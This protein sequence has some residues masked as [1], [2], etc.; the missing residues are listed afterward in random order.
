MFLYV[1]EPKMTS[2]LVFLVLFLGLARKLHR[3]GMFE[4]SVKY[5]IILIF[6]LWL[7]P[8]YGADSCSSLL[9]EVS[10]V[11]LQEGRMVT[12]PLK[13]L[14]QQGEFGFF[15]GS[16]IVTFLSD[17]EGLNSPL[18]MGVKFLDE[19]TEI[20]ANNILLS[21]RSAPQD[22]L[23]Q[24]A[25]Q[26]AFNSNKTYFVSGRLSEVQGEWL[27]LIERLSLKEDV[28]ADTESADVIQL[29]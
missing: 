13:N 27:F 15:E 7:N 5:L 10:G 16:H 22:T 25:F 21:S 14:M 2:D 24:A 18:Q 11:F 19:D 9:G 20:Q 1:R 6:S 17:R 12:E 28:A 3:Q 29:F 8:A 4:V 23:S 26:A